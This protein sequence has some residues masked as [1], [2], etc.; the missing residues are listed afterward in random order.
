MDKIVKNSSE[1]AGGPC[2]KKIKPKSTSYSC[3]DCG[4]DPNCCVCEKCFFYGDHRNHRWRSYQS[5]DGMCDCGDDDAWKGHC[6]HHSSNAIGINWKNELI[7][8]PWIIAHLPFLISGLLSSCAFRP[9]TMT[10]LQ[11]SDALTISK[12]VVTYV[13]SLCKSTS[14]VR[15]LVAECVSEAFVM[16]P[17]ANALCLNLRVGR[18]AVVVN[19]LGNA[20]RTLLCTLMFSSS[21]KRALSMELFSDYTKHLNSEGSIE[22]LA[23]QYLG[24]VNVCIEV[25]EDLNAISDVCSVLNPIIEAA[26]PSLINITDSAVFS[27]THIIRYF[28]QLKQVANH[29]LEHPE[30]HLTPI[31][32]TFALFY[33][34]AM[35]HRKMDVHVE[36]EY[37]F[38][39][40]IKHVILCSTMLKSLRSWIPGCSTFAKPADAVSQ[41]QLL[42]KCWAACGKIYIETYSSAVK[43][44]KFIKDEPGKTGT[45]IAVLASTFGSLGTVNMLSAACET[46]DTQEAAR[47][48]VSGVSA[49]SIILAIMDLLRTFRLCKE[50]GSGAWVRN[51]LNF[52]LV[53]RNFEATLSS[54]YINAIQV[55][56]AILRMVLSLN[57]QKKCNSIKKS[58]GITEEFLKATMNVR[59]ELLTLWFLHQLLCTSDAKMIAVANAFEKLCFS[60]DSVRGIETVSISEDTAAT[61]ALK[62]NTVDAVLEIIKEAGEAV[63]DFVSSAAVDVLTS[64]TLVDT[65]VKVLPNWLYIELAIEVLH[66]IVVSAGVNLDSTELTEHQNLDLDEIETRLAP[67]IHLRAML[68]FAQSPLKVRDIDEV[69]HMRKY[70]YPMASTFLETFCETSSGGNVEASERIFRLSSHGWKLVNVSMADETAFT[71]IEENRKQS[72]ASVPKRISVIGGKVGEEG[73]ITKH[74]A[75]LQSFICNA[76]NNSVMF[77]FIFALL[78]GWIKKGD[79][80]SSTAAARISIKLCA[81]I[82]H[83]VHASTPEVEVIQELLAKVQEIRTACNYLPHE[84]NASAIEAMAIHTVESRLLDAIRDVEGEQHQVVEEVTIAPSVTLISE[85]EGGMALKPAGGTKNAAAKARYN[86]MMSKMKKNMAKFKDTLEESDHGESGDA[87]NN[88]N[89]NSS[90]IDTGDSALLDENLLELNLAKEDIDLV[91][92]RERKE[93]NLGCVVCL[94]KSKPKDGLALLSFVEPGSVATGLATGLSATSC[95]HYMHSSCL[96]VHRESSVTSEYGHYAYN[97]MLCPLCRVPFN[98]CV[99]IVN[100][101]TL[102]IGLLEQPALLRTKALRW[103]VAESSNNNSSSENEDTFDWRM[104]KPNQALI[105]ILASALVSQRVR[106]DGEMQRTLEEVRRGRGLEMMGHIEEEMGGAMANDFEDDDQDLDL[107]EDWAGDEDGFEDWEDEIDELDDEEEEEEESSD[108]V[109][110][111]IDT[112][113]SSIELVGG[114]QRITNAERAAN[115]VENDLDDDSVWEEASVL[116][117]DAQ[118]NANPT[119]E[120]DREIDEFAIFNDPESDSDLSASL[121]ANDPHENNA[122]AENED[123]SLPDIIYLNEPNPNLQRHLVEGD[124]LGGI[125]GDGFS[126][127]VRSDNFIDFDTSNNNANNNNNSNNNNNQVDNNDDDV[128]MESIQSSNSINQPTAITAHRLP[129]TQEHPQDDVSLGF[130]T[131]RES[132][133]PQPVVPKATTTTK[134]RVSSSSQLSLD[135]HVS[136]LAS[137]IEAES[138]RLAASLASLPSHLQLSSFTCQEWM[139]NIFSTLGLHLKLAKLAARNFHTAPVISSANPTA[140]L[141][142]SVSSADQVNALIS[143]CLAEIE[144]LRASHSATEALLA[145]HG[146]AEGGRAAFVTFVRALVMASTAMAAPVKVLKSPFQIRHINVNEDVRLSLFKALCS[147]GS[148]KSPAQYSCLLDSLTLFLLVQSAVSALEK[149]VATCHWSARLALPASHP[150]HPTAN[151]LLAAAA[152][153]RIQWFLQIPAGLGKKGSIDFLSTM[154]SALFRSEEQPEIPEPQTKLLCDIADDLMRMASD[155]CILREDEFAVL[156]TEGSVRAVVFHARSDKSKAVH[157]NYLTGELSVSLESKREIDFQLTFGE[158]RGPSHQILKSTLDANKIIAA[159]LDSRRLSLGKLLGNGGV[160]EFELKPS[161]TGAFIVETVLDSLMDS[162]KKSTSV[163]VSITAASLATLRKEIIAD[164]TKN[165]TGFLEFAAFPAASLFTFS[166]VELN[167]LAHLSDDTDAAFQALS[168]TLLPAESVLRVGGAGAYDKD[169]ISVDIRTFLKSQI[170][171]STSVRT[172]ALRVGADSVSKLICKLPPSMYDVLKMLSFRKCVKCNT[173]PASGAICLSCGT[174]VCQKNNCCSHIVSPAEDQFSE[175]RPEIVR[176]AELCGGGQGNFLT[177]TLVTSVGSKATRAVRVIRPFPYSD[178]LGDRVTST[179]FRKMILRDVHIEEFRNLMLKRSAAR[180]GCDEKNPHAWLVA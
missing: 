75:K 112:S 139:T 43:S 53:Q 159:D 67:S 93:S 51:G 73:G 25:M 103:R 157:E 84:V 64:A 142:R 36:H 117:A 86:A 124:Q 133:Q 13:D 143:I 109:E 39:M 76:F 145:S 72:S 158:V 152:I 121:S 65:N 150:L 169:A 167:T 179:K 83:W 113:I 138:S 125:D 38:S 62:L 90:S 161:S 1:L 116:T 40:A 164:V 3:I 156:P 114:E 48:A 4:V 69:L 177:S 160:S 102:K 29:A 81:L 61:R 14:I 88:A 171:D 52:K 47:D 70:D 16:R 34:A 126:F 33:N 12:Q 141:A 87:A 10:D 31:F 105:D 23:I 54:S 57:T 7:E 165:I 98:V 45:A 78:N 11:F 136:R 135:A 71:A 94:E 100:Q 178:E 129:T 46:P 154:R 101:T 15:S 18:L 106:Q 120:H 108:E 127:V 89:L 146:D 17:L 55:L 28:F 59:T 19:Q 60:I 162:L 176:H 140:N 180:D 99:P 77:K 131:P 63:T 30:K 149:H 85:T 42:A 44:R 6:C 115:F 172:P 118:Q 41:I 163:S 21:I 50:I 91:I 128:D 111:E 104:V 49:V 66:D 148:V 166:P 170:T 137:Q 130:L 20:V 58:S 92:D 79:A 8:F 32:K 119:D 24:S 9:K 96:K 56:L 2:G 173:K 155:S 107:L 122:H 74:S 132:S 147:G 37:P 174:L 175:E 110:V 22:D 26:C 134:V 153:E 97:E 168:A 144:R 35:Y 123:S 27:A 151:E 5:N 95:G 82:S 68:S 80:T